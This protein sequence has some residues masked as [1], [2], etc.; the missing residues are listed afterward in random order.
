MEDSLYTKKIVS[1]GRLMITK[2]EN[3]EAFADDDAK[4]NQ[5]VVAGNK[6]VTL[7]TPWGLQKVEDLP[8]ELK[9][10]VREFIKKN[11]SAITNAI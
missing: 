1:L 4:W 7:G 8:S 9:S 11:P 2:C 10:V 6:L 3:N 5:C